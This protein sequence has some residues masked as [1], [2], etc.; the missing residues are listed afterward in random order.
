M[1]LKLYY[2]P[3]AC[4]LSPH[5]A[6][7]EADLAF[8]LEKVDLRAKKT[9]DGGDYVGLNSKGYVPALLLDDGTLLTEGVA[10]VQY[11][12]DLVPERG[13]APKCGTMERVHLWEWL[14]FIAT[15]LHKGIS[16]LYRPQAT[17]DLKRF[18]R[19]RVASRLGVMGKHLEER[20]FLVGERFT[21]ADGYAF[22]ALRSWVSL[23]GELSGV[24]AAYRDRIAARPAV[25]A[26]LAAEGLS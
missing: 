26:A 19:D 5:I 24:L 22:Y 16:P 4:S 13:L 23:K 2:T 25:K 17:D 3:G 21:V 11:V 7:R 18:F 12:A 15:E 8:D 20:S 10:I 1:T 6:L 14:N 9:S